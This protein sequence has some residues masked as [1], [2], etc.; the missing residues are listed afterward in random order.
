M[1]STEKLEASSFLRAKTEKIWN[2]RLAPHS[3]DY[4]KCFFANARPEPVF[5]YFS[6]ATALVSFVNSTATTKSH[7]R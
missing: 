3:T 6:N 2:S 4:T 1:I 5:R 7:G